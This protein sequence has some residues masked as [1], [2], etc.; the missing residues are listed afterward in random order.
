[1]SLPPPSRIKILKQEPKEEKTFD[2]A[3]YHA[4]F[5][6]AKERLDRIAVS[7]LTPPEDFINPTTL[8][9]D[10]I[11]RDI[12]RLR[13]LEVTAKHIGFSTKY[14]SL[15]VSLFANEEI[16]TICIRKAKDKAG[17]PVK[18]KT[19]GSKRFM[20]YRIFDDDDPSLFIG[21][22]IGE[23]LLL[24]LLEL[25]YLIIQSDSIAH[26]LSSNPY[27]P[28]IEDRYIFALLDNDSSCKATIEP[29]RAHFESCKVF[30]LDFENIWDKKLPKG[31]DFRDFCNQIAKEIRGEKVLADP[32]EVKEAI[33]D[34]LANEIKLLLGGEYE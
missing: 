19:F 22:G 4:N 8:L 14:K 23:F 2:L 32:I 6:A 24:E 13:G 17:N 30:G 7:S 12:W 33:I 3:K 11:D 15:T 28:K 20:P 5:K 18:W 10:L 25:N 21:F 26:N 34:N 29:L 9:Y 16:K 1:M 27:T 31:Y